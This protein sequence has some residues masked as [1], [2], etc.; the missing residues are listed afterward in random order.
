[1]TPEQLAKTKELL[2]EIVCEIRIWSEDYYSRS[3]CL[4]C[5]K[6]DRNEQEHHDHC[7]YVRASALLQELGG[8]V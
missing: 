1:M 5:G 8:W 3:Y 6:I 4:L 2:H 7:V